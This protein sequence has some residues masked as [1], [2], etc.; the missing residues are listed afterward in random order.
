MEQVQDQTFM[1]LEITVQSSTDRPLSKGGQNE[2]RTSKSCLRDPN[3]SDRLANI[4]E[5]GPQNGTHKV[6]DTK[7]QKEERQLR[8]VPMAVVEN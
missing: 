8:S 3:E 6:N 7:T 4:S 2:K 5:R 1:N